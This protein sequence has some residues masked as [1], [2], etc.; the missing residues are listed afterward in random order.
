M[1]FG[2]TTTAALFIAVFSGH[3]FVHQQSLEGSE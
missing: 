1:R 3:A 2:L